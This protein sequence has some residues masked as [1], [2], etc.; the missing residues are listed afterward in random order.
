M[1][2]RGNRIDA[3]QHYWTLARDDYGWL[4]PAVGRIYDDFLPDRL[5][6]HLEKHGM[7]GTILVQAAPTRAETEF[8]LELADKEPTI[9]GVVGWLDFESDRFVSEWEEL[10]AHPKFA[11]IRPMIQD[12][13][14]DWILRGKV[15]EHVRFLAD[16]GF[17]IDLQAN[18]RHLPYLFELMSRVPHLAG[19]IDHLGKPDKDPGGAEAWRVHMKRLAAYPGLM[20]KLSGMVPEK[21]GATWSAEEI[22]P[23]ARFAIESFGPERVMFGSDWPVCLLSATYDEV[24]EL[25]EMCVGALSPEEREDVCGR[26]ALRF[27][28]LG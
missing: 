21:D 26:N 9:L 19:V 20:C 25:F 22:V 6:P 1:T 11:G 16:R 14:S 24:V 13:P 5:K 3:H 4:T 15:L 27:Y 17:P 12:L 7:D 8:M 23:R 28:R 2:N 18:P 10:A